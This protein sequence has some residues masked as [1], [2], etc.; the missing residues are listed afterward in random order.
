[1][2]LALR[3]ALSACGLEV[4]IDTKNLAPGEDLV[5]FARSSVRRADATICVISTTSLSSA[6]VTRCV[7]ATM[8]LGRR[9]CRRLFR[10]YIDAHERRPRP[11]E[12]AR[13]S[14]L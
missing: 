8:G 14:S 9:H 5:N 4:I 6:W 7:T 13:P 12:A 2:A 10:L 11:P 1:M 3:G